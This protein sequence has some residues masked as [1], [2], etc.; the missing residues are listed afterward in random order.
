MFRC[1]VNKKAQFI[2]LYMKEDCQSNLSICDRFPVRVGLWQK[3]A[4][5][6]RAWIR[7]NLGFI[8]TIFVIRSVCPKFKEEPLYLDAKS[9]RNGTH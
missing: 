9:K 1:P 2:P 8:R 4:G 6:V 3:F 7:L 5:R